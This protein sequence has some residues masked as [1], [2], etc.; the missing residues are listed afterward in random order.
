MKSWT[1]TIDPKSIPD[2]VLKAERAR[3]NAAKRTTFGGGRPR[4]CD[5]GNCPLCI[6]RAKRRVGAKNG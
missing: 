3:R 6:A 1:P 4:S 2:D 5:C